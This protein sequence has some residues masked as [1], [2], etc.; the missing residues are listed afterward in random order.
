MIIIRGN[1][2]SFRII[3]KIILAL[4]G[5]ESDWVPPAFTLNV[6]F[7]NVSPKLIIP[8]LQKLSILLQL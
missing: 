2:L 3:V 1:A 4:V 5:L 6:C 7:H 8:R